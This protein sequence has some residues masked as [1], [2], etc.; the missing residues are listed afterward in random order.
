MIVGS[1]GGLS[2]VSIKYILVYS[3]ITNLGYILYS[4][5][6]NNNY[7]LIAYLFNIAQYS[8]THI[9]LFMIV[10]TVM[11]YYTQWI[12]TQ[13]YSST[14]T[15]VTSNILYNINLYEILGLIKCNPILVIC[16]IIG[17][18]SLIGI[19]PLSGFYGKLLLLESG[20]ISGSWLATLVLITTS[21]I[22]AFYYA[23]IMSVTTF[24]SLSTTSFIS[25]IQSSNIGNSQTLEVNIVVA[26]IISILTV[27]ILLPQLLLD[28]Y[29]NGLLILEYYIYSY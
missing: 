20:L 29:I 4:L 18:S 6:G 17:L 8:L 7:T 12:T 2:Q 27:A 13:R 19:P 23:Y 10:L 14:S 21:I 3:S 15:Q 1:L 25:Y 24:K 22:T 11:I 28:I 16:L 9:L 26:Y 5:L